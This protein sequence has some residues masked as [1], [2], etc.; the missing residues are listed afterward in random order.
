MR[1]IYFGEME[2][3]NVLHNVETFFN[4]Q[5]QYSWLED[6]FVVEL[7]RSVDQSVVESP[8]CIKSPV[9]RQIPPTRLSGG[10]KAVILMK[11][12]PDRVINASNCGDNCAEWILQLGRERDLTINLHHIMEFPD[13]EFEIEI[14][15]DHIFVHNMREMVNAAIDYL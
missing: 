3:V 11:Y 5:Y 10:T 6:K 15:N 8:E 4:N 13:E 14:L 7:I 12:C 9:L 1:R 2:N